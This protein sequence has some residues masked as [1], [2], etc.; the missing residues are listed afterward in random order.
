MASSRDQG[1]A[2]QLAPEPAI[3]ENASPPSP[4]PPPAPLSRLW[5][6]EAAALAAIFLLTWLLD[7]FVAGLH[8]PPA[9][10]SLAVA[11]GLTAIAAVTLAIR[12]RG[13]RQ[14]LLRQYKALFDGNPFPMWIYDVD[15]YRFLA[16][17]DSA[18]RQYGY[19]R[20]E[21]LALTILD[22][23]PPED[24]ER[25]KAA[26]AGRGAAPGEIFRH[27]T[28]SG[29]LLQV[30]ITSQWVRWSGHRARMTLARDVTTQLRTQARLAR[31][32]ERLR[33][34]LESTGEGI[35]SVN[36]DH[37]CDWCNPAAARLLGFN[38]IYDII[39]KNTHL[40][41]H[42]T[43]PDG[44]PYPPE[45]CR[46][47]LAAFEGKSIEADDEMLW[48]ADGTGFHA[49]YRSYPILRNGRPE[50]A[51]V[52]FFDVDEKLRAEKALRRSEA[53]FRALADSGIVGLAIGT[54][55][56]RMVE[57]NDAFLDMLAYSRP[58]LAAGLVR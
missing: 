13:A 33:L 3:R 5:I 9:L 15:T 30:Q 21:F 20:K 17:N 36:L 8:G 47:M 53:R 39:G 41:I 24:R 6:R 55:E 4:A 48:R 49:S 14:D 2:T 35:Y 57:A 32:E 34:V 16:V 26:V 22:I 23:R 56:G 7:T 45:Q 10:H 31:S 58:D 18:C 38:S 11:A 29:E 40:L 50:G 25:V 46:I 19:T 43:R 52:T 37:V 27:L 12:F 44:S 51:V 1:E 28:K 42:H 54:N